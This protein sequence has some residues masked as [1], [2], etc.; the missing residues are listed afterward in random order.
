MHGM[1]YSIL[2]LSC[3]LAG[4]LASCIQVSF[5]LDQHASMYPAI[6][7]PCLCF[8]TQCQ[9]FCPVTIALSVS[10]QNGKDHYHRKSI[11]SL[12]ILTCSHS[13]HIQYNLDYPDPFVPETYQISEI[14]GQNSFTT[15]TYTAVRPTL[16]CLLSQQYSQRSVTG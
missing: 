10:Q 14:A 4:K 11:S 2:A 1:S 8:L 3:H 5:Q 16:H 13:S 7:E 9:N 12:S 6:S 15:P